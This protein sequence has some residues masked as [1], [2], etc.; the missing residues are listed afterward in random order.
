MGVV[1]KYGNGLQG[2]GRRQGRRRDPGRRPLALLLVGL[3]P[4]ANGDSAPRI[5]FF[6]R[7]P[8]NA[9]I[10]ADLAASITRRSRA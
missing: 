3:S 10:S 6:G 2:P 4:V 9:I 5:I 7:V 8:S 1:T